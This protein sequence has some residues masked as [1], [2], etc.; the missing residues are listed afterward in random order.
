MEKQLEL[1]LINISGNDHPGVT[2]ALTEI[3]ARYGAV[4]LDIGQSNIHHTLSLG[5]LFKTDSSVSGEI[6]K[7]L[8]FKAS[9]L[10]KEGKA[11]ILRPGRAY[12]I[13]SFEKDI[14]KIK[15][16]YNHGYMLAKKKL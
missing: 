3:L 7:E 14:D 8:L 12:Q 4:I 1:I 9:E 15:L 11:I 13:E 16:I 6:M 5:I 10:E 2:A